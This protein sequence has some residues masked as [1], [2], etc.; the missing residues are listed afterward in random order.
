[1]SLLTTYEPK[2][3]SN[4]LD[5]MFTSNL[6]TRSLSSVYP[7]V[8]VKEEKDRFVLTAEMPGL[9]KDDIAVDVKNGVLTLSGEKKHEHADKREGY[10]YSER[11]YGKF[12]RSFNLSDSVSE[13]GVEAEYKDGVLTVVLK[14]NKEREA[15]RIAI[16]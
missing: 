15:K 5:D 3:L 4:W 16:R 2:T 9:N 13:D 14:K 1:M 11:S 12:S 10:F 7:Q 6:E 8:E